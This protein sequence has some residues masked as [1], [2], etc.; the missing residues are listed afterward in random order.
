[1]IGLS[2]SNYSILQVENGYTLF[3]KNE[4]SSTE[5]AWV[6]AEYDICFAFMKHLMTEEL[7][8]FNEV[9]KVVE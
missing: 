3:K 9:P 5:K 1:M 7:T 2:T 4:H 6:F 8:K